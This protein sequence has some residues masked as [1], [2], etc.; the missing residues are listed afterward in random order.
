ML[1]P[2]NTHKEVIRKVQLISW[3]RFLF[4]GMALEDPLQEPTSK[5]ANVKL[6]AV[7]SVSPQTFS[8]Q[9]N[10]RVDDNNHN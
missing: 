7:I 9:T 6:I 2:K 5:Y 10:F 1:P 3:Y 8:I 4:I